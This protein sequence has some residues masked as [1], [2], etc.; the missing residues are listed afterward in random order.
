MGEHKGHGDK[1][2]NYPDLGE[3]GQ[4]GSRAGANAGKGQNVGSQGGMQNTGS[5][6]SG[7]QQDTDRQTVDKQ[8]IGPGSGRQQEGKQQQGTGSQQGAGNQRQ[9]LQQGGQQ[10][11][12]G[13]AAQDDLDADRNIRKQGPPG[14]VKTNP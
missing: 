8:S 1:A 12:G 2:P 13:T 7:K 5:Q 10:S 9:N 6:Q 3:S 4:P 11:T 14:S